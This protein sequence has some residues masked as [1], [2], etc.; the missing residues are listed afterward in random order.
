[1][2]DDR[3]DAQTEAD[4]DA[5]APPTAWPRLPAEDAIEEWPALRLW[6]E[7]LQCRFPHTLRLPNCWWQHNDL[8]EILV[9]LRD[10]ERGAYASS[11]LPGAAMDWHRAFRDAEVRM[12]FWIKRFGCAVPGREHPAGTDEAAWRSFVAAD[13]AA[14]RSNSTNV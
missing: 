13:V 2:N 5:T 12:E 9:A 4:V 10:H 6:V 8:V 11:A 7:Q 3:S 14:R 1:M